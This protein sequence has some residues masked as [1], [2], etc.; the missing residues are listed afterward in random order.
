MGNE[1]FLFYRNSLARNLCKEYRNEFKKD[2][3]N[4]E[5]LFK[6]CLRQQSIPYFATACYQKWGLDIDF[7][8]SEYKDYINGKYIA[9]DCDKISGYTYGLWCDNNKSININLDIAH[10][11]YCNCTIS[12]PKTKCPTLYISNKSHIKI[13]G[14]GFNSIRI[15]LFDESIVDIELLDANSTALIYKYSNDCNVIIDEKCNCKIK[16]FYKDLKL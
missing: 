14:N 6:L 1:M 10:L 12:I 11:L 2:L 16:Q 4:K 13:K 15:Y 3:D 7:L 5:S 8:K 9:K